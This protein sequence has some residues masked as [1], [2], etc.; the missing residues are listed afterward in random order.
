[1][2]WS[3]LAFRVHAAYIYRL[4]VHAA[5]A[6]VV[7]WGVRADVA[8]SAHIHYTTTLLCT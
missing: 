3:V 1:M 4:Q 2:F 7:A 5:A 8:E 6:A